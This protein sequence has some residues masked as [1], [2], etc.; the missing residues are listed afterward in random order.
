MAGV[1]NHE[2]MNAA[3][4][5]AAAIPHARSPELRAALIRRLLFDLRQSFRHPQHSPE[6]GTHQR[7]SA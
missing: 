1:L 7:R 4:R 2:L 3:R 5:R 6:T